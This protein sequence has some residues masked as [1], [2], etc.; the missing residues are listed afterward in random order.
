GDWL[1]LFIPYFPQRHEPILHRECPQALASPADDAAAEIRAAQW[2][3]RLDCLA[4]LHPVA[5][6][7]VPVTVPFDAAEDPRM[8]QRGMLA[9]IPVAD[10]ARGR[11]ELTVGRPP[12]DRD[13]PD[14]DPWRI[15][16]WR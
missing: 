5:I 10:L 13:D 4:R 1:R 8:D 11:H 2:R 6:D 14:P 16:F 3:S 9:M 7:G 12:R 15:P